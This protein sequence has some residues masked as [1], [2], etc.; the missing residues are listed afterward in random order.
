MVLKYRKIGREAAIIN[1]ALVLSGGGAGG[2]S[3]RGNQAIIEMGIDF[4]LLIGTSIGALNAALL[5]EFI[6]RKLDRGEIA[7]QM[8]KAWYKFGKFMTLNCPAFINNLFTPFRIP[9]IYTN[10]EIKK[11]LQAYIPPERRFSDYRTCQLSVTG[12]NLSRKRLDIFD[13]NSE[14][15]VDRAVLASM[16]YPVAFPA[17]RIK[18]DYYVDGGA[19]SNAL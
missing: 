6:Y 7:E 18:G 1:T 3:G 19:L 10:R 16:A 4:D 8:E 5:A 2:L 15:P 11:V 17:I 12:T 9:S 13:F 14:V